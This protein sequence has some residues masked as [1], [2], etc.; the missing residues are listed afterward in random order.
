MKI[1]DTIREILKRKGTEVWSITP[2]STVYRAIEIMA[3]KHIGALLVIAG[4]KLAGIISERDY[5]RKVIL[6][7]KSS[8]TTL[9]SDIMTRAVISV[10][11]G[12]TV[13]GCMRI[14]TNNRVRHLPVVENEKVVG[15]LSIGDLV[16]WI[17]FV[18]KKTIEEL[19][20]HV[21][22]LPSEGDKG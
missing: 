18:Q 7:G 19:K 9:V 12:E 11:P 20:R 10:A 16:N 17:M 2:E 6:L 1:Y 5:A 13:D 14:M 3:D 15:V 22:G 4:D 21:A 8:R